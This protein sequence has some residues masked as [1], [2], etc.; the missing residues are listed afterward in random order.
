MELLLSSAFDHISSYDP[1][2]VRRGLRHIEGL[3]AKLCRPYAPEP[4]SL[5]PSKSDGPPPTGIDSLIAHDDPAYREFLRLQDGF[6]WNLALRLVACLE[7]LLGQ[8]SNDLA[9]LLILST[10]DLLQGVLL[11][12]PPSR[13]VF[14]RAVNMTILLDLLEP[15]SSPPAIQGATVNT[16]V[17]AL[18][19]EWPNVRTFEALEGL[20]SI[21]T[22]F[23]RKET[24][25]EVKLRILEFL[26]FYL[27]PEP[28]AAEPSS[29][30]HQAKTKHSP[31]GDS[32]WSDSSDG[33]GHGHRVRTTQEKQHM[34]RKYL[35]NVDSL[36][37]ELRQSQPFGNSMI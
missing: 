34:L 16:L 21:C 22:L 4:A 31:P 2:T 35:S 23:K 14:A 32:G 33:S 12:H 25:K 28:Q 37:N 15:Q 24:E 6:E 9:T 10:L 3:L 20:E 13:R 30:H 7:R 18:V 36:V 5:S 27:I 8:G 11:I 29:Q 1:A 19:D 26:F 17:C